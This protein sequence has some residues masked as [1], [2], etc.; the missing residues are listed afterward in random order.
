MVLRY[1]PYKIRKNK[2]KKLSKNYFNKTRKEKTENKDVDA[3]SF[4]F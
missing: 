3:S 4:L 2:S 1:L